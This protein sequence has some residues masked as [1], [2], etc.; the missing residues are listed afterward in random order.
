MCG[1]ESKLRCDLRLLAIFVDAAAIR[2]FWEIQVNRCG[3]WAEPKGERSTFHSAS[4]AVRMDGFRLLFTC[5][6]CVSY[7][8]YESFVFRC[9]LTVGFGCQK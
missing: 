3:C 1:G 2:W 5:C 7:E 8:F 4:T 9:C 6:V